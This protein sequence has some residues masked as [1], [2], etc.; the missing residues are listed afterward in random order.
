MLERRL[1]SLL[2][3]FIL[4]VNLQRLLVGISRFFVVTRLGICLAQ[5]V[6]RGK[7]FW[8]L[9]GQLPQDCD[10]VIVFFQS[11]ERRSL[12]IERRSVVGNQG[13]RSATFR[14][15]LV[16]LLHHV[17][18][19][20]EL[21]PCGCGIGRKLSRLLEW[22]FGLLILLHAQER[23]AQH[24]LR[25]SQ[26]RLLGDDRAQLGYGARGVASLQRSLGVVV[27]DYK[28]RGAPYHA[29]AVEKRESQQRENDQGGSAPCFRSSG[30]RAAEQRAQNQA[31]NQSA[32]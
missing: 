21:D 8:M 11:D 10:G 12:I 19:I 28:S 3:L 26:P 9:F 23:L 22:G 25:V 17:V 5:V 27:R 1:R 7:H 18:K 13:E 29:L 6:P 14:V 20:A 24:E 31:K 30:E 4:R 2:R 15:S 16:K 32:D